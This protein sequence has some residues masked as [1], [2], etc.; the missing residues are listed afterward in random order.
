MADH[1]G[2]MSGIQ[3]AESQGHYSFQHLSSSRAVLYTAVPA[4]RS[5]AHLNK[6]TNDAVGLASEAYCIRMSLGVQSCGSQ[7]EVHGAAT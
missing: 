2:F 4:I 3:C 7:H 1:F 5:S 6:Q